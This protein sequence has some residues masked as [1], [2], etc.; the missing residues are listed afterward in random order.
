[1]KFEILPDP[2]L[3]QGVWIEPDIG[4]NRKLP[5]EQRAKMLVTLARVRDV[6]EI[7]GGN[8]LPVEADSST[9]SR[10]LTI[11]RQWEQRK[12]VLRKHVKKLIGF[13]KAENGEFVDIATIEGLLDA[14]ERGN[15]EDGLWLV[16]HLYDVIT[17]KGRIDLVLEQKSDS[18]SE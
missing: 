13:K 11:R 15:D 7:E 9:D 14:I 6:L 17:R 8:L 2:H 10:G 18:L 12:A 5:P 4:G 16:H 3:Q 1:M